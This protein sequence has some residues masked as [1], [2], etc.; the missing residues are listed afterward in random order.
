MYSWLYIFDEFKPL[1]TSYS[2]IV[3]YL[4]RDPEKLLELVL[5][6]TNSELKDVE[7]FRVHNVYMDR[8]GGELLVELLIYCSLGEVSAK[9][10]VSPNPLETLKKYYNYEESKKTNMKP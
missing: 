10:I 7:K 8:E 3:Y 1:D 2:E 6:A 5:E 9:I 4:N